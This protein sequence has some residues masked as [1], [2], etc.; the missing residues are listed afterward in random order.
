M[1][2][3][4]CELDR[5][6]D[7]ECTR[8]CDQR[9]VVVAAADE[10]K[11]GRGH[12]FEHAGK[13]VEE[14]VDA[15][16]V[17]MARNADDER[18]AGGD[19]RARSTGRGPLELGDV[20]A[21]RHDGDRGRQTMTQHSVGRGLGDGADPCAARSQEHRRKRLLRALDAVHRR[22]QRR[23]RGDQRRDERGARGLG[24][25]HVR[26]E[27]VQQRAQ[28]ACPGA[29]GSD[30]QPPLGDE[31]VVDPGLLHDADERHGRAVRD[32]RPMPSCA[33]TACIGEV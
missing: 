7:A 16:D 3:E 2:L 30:A 11:S 19:R 4:A 20:D 22:E 12:G 26:G 32:Q 18:P 28:T 5:V 6:C 8:A 14:D 25:D 15:L 17:V 31:P 33:E 21:R 27:F 23:A 1:G 10:L 29:E 24:M 9:L 13:R